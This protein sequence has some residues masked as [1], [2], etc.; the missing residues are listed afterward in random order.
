MTLSAAWP[1]KDQTQ[2]P[3]T[4]WKQQQ[5]LNQQQQNHRF[6]SDSS[7]CHGK[8]VGL[9]YIILTSWIMALGSAFVITQKMLSLCGVFLL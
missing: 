2:N 4:Q 1:N 9:N 6:R 5:T 3:H 8:G 7:Q